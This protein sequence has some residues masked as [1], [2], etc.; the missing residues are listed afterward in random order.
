MCAEVWLCRHEQQTLVRRSAF[1][2]RELALNRAMTLNSSSSDIVNSEVTSE[3][4]LHYVEELNIAFKIGTFGNDRIDGSF[5]GDGPYYELLFE[6]LCPK[7]TSSDCEN[8]FLDGIGRHGFQ[9]ILFEYL[10][11]ILAEL[12]EVCRVLSQPRLLG[13]SCTE[14][15]RTA[16]YWGAFRRTST[17]S[18]CGS[19]RCCRAG[20]VGSALL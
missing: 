3:L 2:T 18:L 8:G 12:T 11:R 14:C 19:S 6:N 9:M 10:Q 7:L 17:F 1:F 4:V 13:Q 5:T 15:G 16:A 20:G